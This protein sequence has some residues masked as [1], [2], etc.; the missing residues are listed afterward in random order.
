MPRLDIPESSPS[1]R[2]SSVASAH[3]L[4]VASE[5]KGILI[6]SRALSSR[7][8][9]W[10]P[11]TPP[12]PVFYQR[13]E[14]VSCERSWEVVPPHLHSGGHRSSSADTLLSARRLGPWGRAARH[15]DSRQPENPTATKRHPAGHR[16][17]AMTR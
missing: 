17:P 4:P 6:I 3:C 8:P 9:P 12:V 5:P 16:S 11:L 10:P 7:F 14:R 13:V 15:S 1:S 2:C